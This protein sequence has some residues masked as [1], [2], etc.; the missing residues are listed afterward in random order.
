MSAHQGRDRRRDCHN[1][2]AP[3]RHQLNE[4]NSRKHGSA[5]ANSDGDSSENEADPFAALN[6]C[7]TASTSAQLLDNADRYIQA[8][9]GI[10]KS[11]RRVTKQGTLSTR[12]LPKSLTV[13]CAD[14][15]TI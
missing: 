2:R 1:V 3:T 10:E 13:A 14:N 12:N 5:H 11:S 9:G 4:N 15:Q 6:Q 7:A 8:I